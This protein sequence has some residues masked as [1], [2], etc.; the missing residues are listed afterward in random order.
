METLKLQD[1]IDKNKLV[2]LKSFP[3]IYD[4]S[5]IDHKYKV[6]RIRKIRSFGKLIFLEIKSFSSEQEIIFSICAQK[7]YTNQFA[8]VNK[9]DLGDNISFI[10]L[11][12]PQFKKPVIKDW[13]LISKT[14]IQHPDKYKGLKD[15]DILQRQRY[16]AYMYDS[17][18]FKNIQ[19]RMK[20]LKNIR[21]VLYELGYNQIDIPILELEYGGANAKAFVC[22]INSINSKGYLSVSPELKLK[23]MIIGGFDK[24]FT[25]THCFRNQDVDRT[26]NPEFLMLECYEIGKDYFE[27]VELFKNVLSCILNKLEVPTKIKYNYKVIDLQ[28]FEIIKF[29]DLLNKYGIIQENY[30]EL[31]K[32]ND[33]SLTLDKDNIKLK[34]FDKLVAKD[35]INPTVVINFPKCSSPLCKPLNKLE[36]QQAEIY[37]AGL[38]VANI[39]SE[40]NDP[41]R[42]SNNLELA[43]TRNPD[44]ELACYYGFP[45]TGGI[46]IGLQRIL[47]ILT[48]TYN[49]RQ[50]IP[51]PLYKSG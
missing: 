51:F 25:I 28:K 8:Q 16:L 41:F 20:L 50:S 43:N 19:F 1:K 39:Y 26:H 49:L 11:N 6:G 3:N 18:I 10:T 33:I 4:Y 23:Q 34:L 22:D 5:K 48:N 17:K 31:A 36:I 21:L 42:Q 27:M 15:L 35:L 12:L 14:I 9:L 47:M 30:M 7:N 45:I 38:E 2:K 13:R 29:K 40:E 44:F 46:G 24:I 37:I 32:E